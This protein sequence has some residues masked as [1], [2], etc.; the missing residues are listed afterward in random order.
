MDTPTPVKTVARLLVSIA[1]LTVAHAAWPQG[2]YPAKPVRVVLGFPPASAADLVARIVGAKMG[3]ALT[4]QL[5]IDNRPGASSNIAT[6]AVVRAPA[7]GYTLLMGTVANTIN[8]SLYAKLAFDFA[9]DLAPVAAVASVPNLLVVHPSLPVRSVQELI[10]A[11]K[12]KPGEILYGSSGN[13]TGPH[14]SGELFN[15]MAGVKLVHIPYKGS[16]QAM[17]D[18]LGGRVMVMFSPASTALPHI[19]AG[20]LRALAS[21]GA[22][23]TASAPDLPTIAEAG[24]PGYETTVWFGLL[25]PANT[26]RDIIER[27][28]REVTRAL[29]DADVKK[30]F[31]TQGIDAMGGTPEQFAAYIRDE[32][33]KWARVVQA[34]GAKLD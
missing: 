19:K 23:R 6:E 15:L 32:T 4:Q 20:T 2:A 1:A 33:A 21:S 29:T 26:P 14:L 11:A 17:T 12:T 31:A 28:N 30:Q 24:L 13:G 3:D 22:Q 8:A 5:V 27:L 9:R 7:D 16:P 18:L 25:A 10:K 34:S